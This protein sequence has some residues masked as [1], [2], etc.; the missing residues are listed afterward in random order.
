MVSKRRTIGL[1]VLAGFLSLVAWGVADSSL[2]CPGQTLGDDVGS[3]IVILPQRHVDFHF[4][5]TH[6]QKVQGH[7]TSNASIVLYIMTEPQ[8]QTLNSTG[9]VSSYLWTTGAT[10]DGWL[11]DVDNRCPT[12]TPVTPRAPGYILYDNPTFARAVANILLPIDITPC[13]PPYTG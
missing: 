1:I 2:Y 13:Y 6:Q 4:Q 7:F 11:C 8:F 12:P 10:T 5:T 9:T 3:N